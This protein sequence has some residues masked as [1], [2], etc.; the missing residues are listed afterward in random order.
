MS[1]PVIMGLRFN[2]FLGTP[3]D[4]LTEGATKSDKSHVHLIICQAQYCTFGSRCA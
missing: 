2:D 3:T 4:K 1:S